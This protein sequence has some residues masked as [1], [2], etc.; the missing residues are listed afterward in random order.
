MSKSARWRKGH[1]TQLHTGRPT[2]GRFVYSQY[3]PWFSVTSQHTELE[4]EE[5]QKCCGNLVLHQHWVN[6]HVSST[7]DIIQNNADPGS[8]L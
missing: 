8:V 1:D 5:V 6:K 4:K 2:G 7:C 3:S